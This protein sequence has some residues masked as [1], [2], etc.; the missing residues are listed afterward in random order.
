[1][2][3]L[4]ISAPYH[5]LPPQQ[6]FRSSRARIRG[7][8]GAMG[9]GKS[10][11]ICEEA[12]DLALE[13]PGIRIL[14]ARQRHTSIIETTKKTMVDKVLPAQ[15]LAHP[16]T[17]KKESGGE[18]YIQLPNG[19]TFH[20]VGLED[21][22]RW[23]SS[24][25]GALIFDEA[26]E[27]DE[28]TV[29][30]LI[31][32]LRQILPGNVEAPGSVIIAFNPENPGHWLQ[33]WFILGASRTKFG[34][35]K[36]EVW[37][38]GATQPLGDGEFIFAKATDNTY[39]PATYVDQ[40]LGGL[41]ELLRRRYMEGEWLYT[42]GTSFFDTE[43]L[44]HY[45]TQ[46]GAPRWVGET[47]GA[48]RRL[49]TGLARSGLKAEPEKIR[50]RPSRNGLTFVWEPPLRDR[51]VDGRFR[52]ANRYIVAVD[53]SSGG[54]TDFSAIQVVCVETL[55]Q[56]CEYQGK[57][58]PDLLAIEAYRLGKIYNH[59]LVVPEMTG[60]WGFTIASELKRLGY[61]RLYTRRVKDRLT[62]KWTDKLGWDT[63]LAT[64]ALMLDTLEQALRERSL[65]LNGERSLAELVTFVRDE[66]GRPAA[67]P[68]T[69]DDLVITLAMA[70]TVAVEMPRQLRRAK[71]PEHRPAFAATGY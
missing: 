25:L 59:A 11:A 49:L 67:Q 31:T 61:P 60:G 12:F 35:R 2:T 14:I 7:Y 29:V 70:V 13:F 57:V 5:P 39:L 48:D 37:A 43:A 52:P 3:E 20:F 66:K 42:S 38:T 46:V 55:E 1:L 63:N 26:H 17:R 21:P 10:R 50:I 68:G 22:V 47:V 53:V 41:P 71:Q 65:V 28:D 19:S 30:K 62:Q 64:R 16:E 54:S 44:Q 32:R 69:N 33:R 40:N 15:L 51:I 9:G 24:E 23:F 6:A 45:Q 27:I 18:D 8:G 34:F 56:V 4:K 58:D 36:A